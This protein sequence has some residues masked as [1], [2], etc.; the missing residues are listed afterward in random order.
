MIDSLLDGTMTGV[1][2]GLMTQDLPQGFGRESDQDTGFFDI[3][4][5]TGL[6]TGITTHE[7]VQDLG[8]E[9]VHRIFDRGLDRYQ[10][11]TGRRV[12]DRNF[13]RNQVSTG[14]WTITVTLFA[15]LLAKL[16]LKVVSAHRVLS[17]T[18]IGRFDS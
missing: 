17:L 2:S 10:D 1:W 3:I 18:P 11:S 6:R 16:H 13:D 7:S 5:D 14:V 9:S 12:S 8:Q 15:A 4:Q